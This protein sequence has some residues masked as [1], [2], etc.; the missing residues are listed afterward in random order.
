MVPGLF[1]IPTGVVNTFLLDASDGC[2]LIDAGLPDR[3]L[4]NIVATGGSSA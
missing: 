2:A 4:V 3:V 1:V